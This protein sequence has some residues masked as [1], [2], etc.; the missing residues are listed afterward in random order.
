MSIETQ[1]SKAAEWLKRLRE[2]DAA[3]ETLVEY[4]RRLGLKVGEAYRWKRNWRRTSQWPVSGASLMGCRR[5]DGTRIQRLAVRWLSAARV[6]PLKDY[7][8]AWL[9]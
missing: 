7:V 8:K 9:W 2:Q 6:W 1:E 4:T 5:I 3:D